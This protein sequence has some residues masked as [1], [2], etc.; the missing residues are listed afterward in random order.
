MCLLGIHFFLPLIKVC[1]RTS[2]P[3]SIGFRRLSMCDNV[4]L[5]FLDDTRLEVQLAL[6]A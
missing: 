5:A 3:S 1:I 6:H 4:C 2:E